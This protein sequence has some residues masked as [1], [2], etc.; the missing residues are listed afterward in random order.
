MLQ[1]LMT[2]AFGSTYKNFHQTRLVLQ[3]CEDLQMH[4]PARGYPKPYVHDN[5]QISV[6]HI[7]DWVEGPT[8]SA[9]WRNWRNK[10]GLAQD[11]FALLSNANTSVAGL[12]IEDHADCVQLY[13]L[14]GSP[15]CL[16]TPIPTEYELLAKLT[17]DKYIA[18]LNTIRARYRPADAVEVTDR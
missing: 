13:A 7:V 4:F 18:H 6:N 17:T 10:W 12:S 14:I 1:Q 16:V 2:T 8:G 3:I 11:V 5:T 15:P 9:T